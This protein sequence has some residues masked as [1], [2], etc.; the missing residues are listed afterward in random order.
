MA[1]DGPFMPLETPLII[2]LILLLSFY[3]SKRK[4]G[5]NLANV[6]NIK[7]KE[8]ERDETYTSSNPQ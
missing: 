7:G 4:Y 5:E 6:K 3:F 1:E 8:R 2:K